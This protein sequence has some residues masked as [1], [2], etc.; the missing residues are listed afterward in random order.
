MHLR[1]EE[2]ELHIQHARAERA[3]YFERVAF[4]ALN[5]NSGIDHLSMDCMEKIQLPE[6]G[7]SPQPAETYFFRN[8]SVTPHGIFDEFTG[9]GRV[10]LHSEIFGKTSGNHVLSILDMTIK[11]K[12]LQANNRSLRVNW[13]NWKG[14]K[15]Y[16]VLVYLCLLVDKGL[17]DEAE[18]AFMLAGHTKFSP[19]RM[20]A[21]L[22]ELIKNRDL[23][24]IADILGFVRSE[25][26]KRNEKERQSSYEVLSAEGLTEDG[27]S[28]FFWDYKAQMKSIPHSFKSIAKS[29]QF[30]IHKVDGK[31]VV[32]VKEFSDDSNFNRHPFK[33]P[34]PLTP[35]IRLK[36]SPLKAAKI[37]DLKKYL[38]YVPNGNLSYIP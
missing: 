26:L 22:T 24:E 27:L 31:T 3:L 10:Y 33:P 14:N 9:K 12:K 30:R 25:L 19:D 37:K 6:F 29:H 32:D 18:G 17:Y 23:F 8:F 7:A 38:P 11:M 13:D 21:W 20:F 4:Y 5:S 15:C 36:P 34:G 16:V 28:S 2:H 35:L 1:Q